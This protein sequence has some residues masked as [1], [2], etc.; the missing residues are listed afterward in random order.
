MKAFTKSQILKEA[1]KIGFNERESIAAISKNYEF[2]A[3]FK[4]DYSLKEA[5]MYCMSHFQ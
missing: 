4:S 1:V 5:A 3:K 2:Y